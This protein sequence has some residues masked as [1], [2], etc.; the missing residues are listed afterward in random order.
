MVETSIS[1]KSDSSLINAV[2]APNKWDATTLNYG[3]QI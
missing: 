2:L 3:F 1:E